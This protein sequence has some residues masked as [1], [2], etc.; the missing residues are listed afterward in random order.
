MVLPVLLVSITCRKTGQ[1]K[2]KCAWFGDVM[3]L[4]RAM[5]A[6]EQCPLGQYG[7]NRLIAHLI[8]GISQ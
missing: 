7:S 2:F 4:Y 8:M 3:D 5:L 6:K 1:F